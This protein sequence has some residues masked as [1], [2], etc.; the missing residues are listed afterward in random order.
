MA[1]SSRSKIVSHVQATLSCTQEEARDA[2][3]AVLSGLTEQMVQ[4]SKVSFSG[5]GS[6]RPYERPPLRRFDM[7]TGAIRTL[8]PI[9]R[10]KFVPS[11]KLLDVVMRG[12]E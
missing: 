7:N 8:P 6:F 9:P 12:A 1:T 5:F 2:L 11:P 3:D 10:I 4:G